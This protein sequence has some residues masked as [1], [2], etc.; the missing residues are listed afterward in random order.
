MSTLEKRKPNKLSKKLGPK[1]TSCKHIAHSHGGKRHCVQICFH[2][3]DTGGVY[4]FL[5]IA[6]DT[7]DTVWGP[8]QCLEKK[9]SSFFFVSQIWINRIL[10]FMKSRSTSHRRNPCKVGAKFRSNSWAEGCCSTACDANMAEANFVESERDIN[11]RM[12]TSY[13]GQHQ[14]I[15]L[16]VEGQNN[17]WSCAVLSE[18]MHNQGKIAQRKCTAA[19]PWERVLAPW[20]S[21]FTCKRFVLFWSKCVHSSLK[22]VSGWILLVNLSCKKLGVTTT[23]QSSVCLIDRISFTL[24]SIRLFCLSRNGSLLSQTDWCEKERTIQC[25]V[26]CDASKHLTSKPGKHTDLHMCDGPQETST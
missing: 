4:R 16:L 2:P 12:S 8:W 23:F 6:A 13:I 21:S 26:L 7:V 18:S 20:S 22:C 15:S 10:D 19:V 5:R 11:R 24:C 1:R 3:Q 9:T 14:R 25:A 17:P